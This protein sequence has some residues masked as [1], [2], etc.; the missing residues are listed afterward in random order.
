MIDLKAFVQKFIDKS[1]ET[2]SIDSLT[3]SNARDFLGFNENNKKIEKTITTENFEENHFYHMGIIIICENFVFD[4]KKL[5]LKITS[6]SFANGAQTIGTI[7]SV[8]DDKCKGDTKFIV[9]IIK[10]KSVK[11]EDLLTKKIVLFSNSQTNITEDMKYGF[12]EDQQ[13]LFCL[14]AKYG[15]FY[16]NRFFGKS[17]QTI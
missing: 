6:P 17:S 14:L 8:S 7:M 13:K 15:F 3:N 10:T 1:G 16:K 2:N 12:D 11:N 9:R 5:K 4:K